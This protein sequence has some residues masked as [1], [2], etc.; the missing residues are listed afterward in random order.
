MTPDDI[1][2]MAREA[3]FGAGAGQVW[4]E[5]CYGDGVLCE[6]RP[7]AE[8]KGRAPKRADVTVQ[9]VLA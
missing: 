7:R 6:F 1:I 2:R 9:I 3:G 5:H 8:Y 4:T